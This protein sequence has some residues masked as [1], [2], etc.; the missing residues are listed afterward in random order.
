MINFLGCCPLGPSTLQSYG[1][2]SLSVASLRLV[3]G[4]RSKQFLSAPGT[5]PL[6]AVRSPPPRLVSHLWPGTQGALSRERCHDGL[7]LWE[8]CCQ[9]FL[10][11]ARLDCGIAADPKVLYPPFGSASGALHASPTFSL[12]QSPSHPHVLNSWPAQRPGL[13]SP[14]HLQP[15]LP[16]TGF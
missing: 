3:A 11:L 14:P 5:A 9:G 6:E 15:P 16:S 10:C 8:R 13:L 7:G 12:S 4:G 2:P 1:A